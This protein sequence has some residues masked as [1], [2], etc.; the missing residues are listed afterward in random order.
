M[1]EYLS[2]IGRVLVTPGDRPAE[3]ANVIHKTMQVNEAD[4]K[5]TFET[6]LHSP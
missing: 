6:V 1:V 5:S 2:D 3:K 4:L